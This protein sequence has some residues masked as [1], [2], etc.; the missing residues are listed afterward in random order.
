MPTQPLRRSIAKLFS[1]KVLRLRGL[2][3]S[4]WGWRFVYCWLWCGSHPPNILIKPLLLKSCEGYR[5]YQRLSD[6]HELSVDVLVLKWSKA[7]QQ[8]AFELPPHQDSL[9]VFKPII[10]LYG[11][12]FKVDGSDVHHGSLRGS[13]ITGVALRIRKPSCAKDEGS[14]EAR[15][16]CLK[17]AFEEGTKVIQLAKVKLGSEGFSTG[18]E[19]VE[20]DT[21]EEY[22]TVLL[23]ELS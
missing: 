9:S 15:A 4:E 5:C 23:F 22:A 6:L 16:S 8:T 18:Q 17:D 13:V 14:F 1:R 7:Y 21:L 20:A 3:G 19:D 2:A 11:I 12:S 10:P